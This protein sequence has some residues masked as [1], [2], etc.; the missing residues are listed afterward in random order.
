MV[1][2][3]RCGLLLCLLN[4]LPAGASGESSSASFGEVHGRIS[5]PAK[6]QQGLKPGGGVSAVKILLNGGEFS[7][8]PTADGYFHLSGVPVGSYLLQV[9]HPSLRFDPVRIEASSKTGAVK[10]TAYLADFMHG[11]GA[12]LKYPLGLAPSEVYGYLEQREE[13]NVMTIFK[14]PMALLGLFSFG[15]MFL[16]PKMQPMLDEQRELQEKEK[17]EGETGGGGGGGSRKV[18]ND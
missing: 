3:G 17:Q 2:R 12:K 5:I 1:L 6:F 11:K 4:L 16:L 14:N 18:R 8:M 7:G 10:M 15:A 9:V 13:F